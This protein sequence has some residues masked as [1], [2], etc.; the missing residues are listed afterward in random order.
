MFQHAN[1]GFAFYLNR[2]L[3]FAKQRALL[4]F[5]KLSQN[6]VKG[7]S[8]ILLLQF[9]LKY[10]LHLNLCI[11]NTERLYEKKVRKAN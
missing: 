3:V 5:D 1:E 9:A 2:R 4:L 11:G 8:K 7:V 6:Y 10:F